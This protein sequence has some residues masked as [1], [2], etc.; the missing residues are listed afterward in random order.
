VVEQDQVQITREVHR[1]VTQLSL[2]KQLRV[3]VEVVVK[4]KGHLM[5]ALVEAAHLAKRGHQQQ[6]E[7]E[8]LVKAI[9]AEQ[10]DQALDLLLAGVV[11]V[12]E[13]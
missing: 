4:I 2:V 3:V 9:M 12:R 13:L 11:V 6:Q 1:V 5:V 10:V 8:L 7:R